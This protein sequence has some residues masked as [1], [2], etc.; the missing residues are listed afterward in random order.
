MGCELMARDSD[1]H[2]EIL[3]LEAFAA[4]D[5]NHHMALLE[6]KFDFY[7]FTQVL[8]CILSHFEP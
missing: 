2:C 3:H 5:Q 6:V 4:H 7:A 8:H 1:P